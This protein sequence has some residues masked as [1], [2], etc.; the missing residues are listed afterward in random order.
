VDLPISSHS[1]HHPPPPAHPPPPIPSGKGRKSP[2][3]K[4]PR[5]IRVKT[6]QAPAVEETPRT[7]EAP[8]EPVKPPVTPPPKPAP[9]GP[10]FQSLNVSYPNGLFLTFQRDNAEAKDGATAR[11]LVRLT[12]PIR[13]RNAQLCR[14]SKTPEIPE[15]SRVIT[16]EGAV[17]KRMLDGSTEVLFPDGSVSRSPD[18][19]PITAP[20]HPAPLLAEEHD[21][22]TA[23][24]QSA[25]ASAGS[26]PDSKE[27]KSEPL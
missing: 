15:T 1:Q 21:T 8:V 18:S 16:P 11:L 6:P 25:P 9:A 10:A 22:P 13:V 12:Y 7:P 26:T 3:N 23:D 19:G 24:A 27:Q 2:R 4:S 5:A 14:G 20:C 17:L